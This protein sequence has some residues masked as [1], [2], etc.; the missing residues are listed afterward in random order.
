LRLHDNHLMAV[1]FLRVVT[2][3]AVPREP[4]RA[5]LGLRPP[6]RVKR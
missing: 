2:V 1:I 5:A 3:L 6:A 4:A